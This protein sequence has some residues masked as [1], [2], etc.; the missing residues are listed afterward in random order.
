MIDF[1]HLFICWFTGAC[2]RA[3][4]FLVARFWQVSCLFEKI[5][6]CR[7]SKCYSTS[8]FPCQAFLAKHSELLFFFFFSCYISPK[9]LAN[10]LFIKLVRFFPAAP[11]QQICP[12]VLF[13]QPGVILL[14]QK[15]WFVRK[16]KCLCSL[17]HLSV[18]SGLR[19]CLGTWIK[20]MFCQERWKTQRYGVWYVI[21]TSFSL[22]L[23]IHLCLCIFS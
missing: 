19:C 18:R 21:S 20:A 11:E 8:L 16:N 13:S 22:S 9:E 3:V 7:A 23:C 14:L 15:T 12:W 5:H 4:F 2:N 17:P 1:G 6:F 10:L